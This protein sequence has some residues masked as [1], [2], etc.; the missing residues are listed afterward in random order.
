MA[1]PGQRRRKCGHAMAL[2]D[3]HSHCARCREKGKGQDFCVENPTSADKCP[4]CTT[5]T[6]D[7]RLQLA[8]PAYKIK[9]DKREAKAADSTPS[10][11]E[12]LVDPASVAVIGA[13]DNQ[14][15][16]K[17]S[18]SAP[19]PDKKPKKESKKD[20]KKVK[21]PSSTASTS[22]PTSDDR[23]NDLDN[24]WSERFSR[25]EA[26]IL[27]KSFEPSFT[28]DVK[29]A[30]S[31]SPPQTQNI[32]EPFIRPSTSL[33]GSGFSA[34]KHQPTSK[35]VTSSQ[36]SSNQFTGTGFSATKHQPA[37]QT[38]S[39]R[40]TSTVKFTGQGSSATS[41]QPGSQTK[42]H[43]PGTVDYGTDPQI[44]H[45]PLATDRSLSSDPADTGSPALHQTRRD[46]VSSLSSEAAS[47]S[48]QPPLDLYAEE[49]GE[50][51]EDPDQSVTDQDHPVSEEQNYRDTMQGIRSF[52]AWSNIPEMDNP[53]S[54][55]D[56]N[57][58]AGP[59][60][61]PPGKVSVKMP[62]EDWL[63][64]KLA[65]LNLTLVEGYP[66]RGSEPGGLA[67]D[68]FLRPA[69]SQ[70]RWYGLHT[71]PTT[72]PSQLSHWS[73]DASKLNSSYGRI[74]KYTGLSST[75]PASRR[76]SQETLRR[77][78]RSAREASVI[79]NQTASFNRCLFKVQQQM[80]D[81][82]KVV[83]S[84]NKG[85]GSAN[86]T[87]AADELNYLIDFNSS[88]S[89]AAAK[90]MEH[91]SDFVFVSMGNLTLV[92]RDAYLSHLRTGIK[93]DTLTALRSAPLH[94]ATLFP[95]AVVKRAEEDIAQFESKGHST[96]SHNKGRY[97]PYER[98]D[99]K[100]SYKDSRSDKPAWKTIGKRN[101]KRGRGRAS[102]YSSRPAKGQQSYK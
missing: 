98:H 5:F 48:D 44:T 78:E 66:T 64:R 80:K 83:K 10:K 94:I 93:P 26:L 73:T 92:R 52:M 49:E 50:L 18:V 14:G 97:H 1:S 57:P 47:L 101:S 51:S 30:P 6:S 29:V 2:F 77:W 15:T 79:C 69:K 27:A 67:K 84:E 40:P 75:P 99:K 76:I 70:S 87:A 74:A 88:I 90:A 71:E 31:H 96:S 91:L 33:P 42:S 37:S 24:K 68:V 13:V 41:H 35:A 3:T 89:Q 43:R 7:Q 34:E 60:T 63:C 25:L 65:K 23:F 72:N 58:F 62:T 56:D 85:K 20:T 55:S 61:A 32:T 100:S 54:T 12:E 8:T 102:T 38:K 19:P 4:I 36:T 9:K 21:S 81:Q 39:S 53:T 28:S 86:F 95:E 82:L 16:V 17:T 45:R 59:K 11:D 22:Q 46:S